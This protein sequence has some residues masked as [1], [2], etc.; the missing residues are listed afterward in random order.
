[1]VF[2]YLYVRS[3]FQQV[4]TATGTLSAA[5]V[6]LNVVPLID[7]SSKIPPASTQVLAEKRAAVRSASQPDSTIAD[8]KLPVNRKFDAIVKDSMKS[9]SEQADWIKEKEDK[10]NALLEKKRDQLLSDSSEVSSALKTQ[11]V[12][13][14]EGIVKSTVE[15][16]KTEVKKEDSKKEEGVKVEAKKEEP[17]KAEVDVKKEESKNKDI[18]SDVKKEEPKSEVKKDEV[19]AEIKKDDAAVKKEEVKPEAKKEEVEAEAKKEETKKD[20]V[21]AEIKKEEPKKEEVKAE[22]KKEEPK[23]ED[24]K[25]EVKKE[26]PKKDEV[27][28]EVKKE[29]PKKEEVKAEMKKEEPK[30]DSTKA[31]APTEEKMMDRFMTKMDEVKIKEPE[32]FIPS[33]K[34]SVEPAQKETQAEKKEELAA[35]KKEEA[36]SEKKDQPVAERKA[37]SEEQKVAPL[38]SPPS[39]TVPETVKA[40]V[41]S[42]EVRKPVVEAA[43]ADSIG[44]IFQNAAKSM[45][46]FFTG[47]G[48]TTSSITRQVTKLLPTDVAKE[49]E[50]VNDKDVG[51]FTSVAFLATTVGGFVIAATRDDEPDSKKLRDEKPV[52]GENRS[53]RNNGKSP[54]LSDLEIADSHAGVRKETKSAVAGST[55]PEESEIRSFPRERPG[56]SW[57]T[58]TSQPIDSRWMSVAPKEMQPDYSSQKKLADYVAGSAKDSTTVGSK[59]T[60]PESSRKRNYRSQ[61]AD[62]AAL[63]TTPQTNP[64]DMRWVSAAPKEQQPDNSYQT[65]QNLRWEEIFAATRGESK[66]DSSAKTSTQPGA[67]SDIE[68][69]DKKLIEGTKSSWKRIFREATAMRNG[70]KNR[71]SAS[72]G[73]TEILSRQSVSKATTSLDPPVSS[74]GENLR[75]NNTSSVS[76]SKKSG[77]I[78]RGP[79]PSATNSGI[80]LYWRAETPEKHGGS[81]GS[82]IRQTV[83]QPSIMDGRSPRREVPQIMEPKLRNTVGDDKL[84][85]EK[86]ETMHEA[87]AMNMN[88]RS[89]N[90]EMP[91]SN[92]E[93]VHKADGD[94]LGAKSSRTIQESQGMDNRLPRLT[95]P[96]PIDRD[97]RKTAGGLNE[98]RTSQ[99]TQE[100]SSA[101]SA[102]SASYEVPQPTEQKLSK[103]EGGNA[104]RVSQSMQ[105]FP[106][107]NGTSIGFEVPATENQ[108]GRESFPSSAA[109]PRA[110]DAVL[111]PTNIGRRVPDKNTKW[112]EG[113]VEYSTTDDEMSKAESP[114]VLASDNQTTP[115]SPWPYVSGE[116]YTAPPNF[117][118]YVD[119]V[120]AVALADFS[121]KEKYSSSEM[122]DVIDPDDEFSSPN[123]S[124]Q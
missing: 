112:T 72:I 124:F 53:L 46:A 57:P 99:T 109:A 2:F 101:M 70:T 106:E 45:D 20:E 34:K 98:S 84:V 27:K 54:S 80:S 6:L 35:P 78:S 55:R 67:V 10:M 15:A 30:K 21:K 108:T 66:D 92:E 36:S 1:L 77:T 12:T 95:V 93:M 8:L 103:A 43:P 87:P 29:I 7:Q 104:S 114:Q 5:Y 38:S 100:S 60:I 4:L 73:V 23:K 82:E 120:A 39:Q 88:G 111:M 3:I 90:S 33:E 64:E 68:A 94:I 50:K 71:P 24:V 115:S 22:V 48:R 86:S 69:F 83:Q 49:F 59:G 113:E 18:Q 107:L 63:S 75:Q 40:P 91:Q 74:D 65:A 96:G 105:G 97:L 47:I 76:R 13:V 16:S 9:S 102:R 123:S 11:S 118:S 14:A 61:P 81:A 58:V 79:Y 42:V 56:G 26:E 110:V 25:T 32:T 17:K 117:G 31:A 52:N 44:P 119:M 62:V 37:S 41:A 122:L 116:I 121:R 89:G 51:L 19:K 28:A 85:P